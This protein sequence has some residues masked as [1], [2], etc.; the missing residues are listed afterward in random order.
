MLGDTRVFDPDSLHTGEWVMER[1]NQKLKAIIF[2]LYNGASVPAEY[3]ELYQE[4]GE[5]Q[6]PA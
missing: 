4:I 3:V 2:A 1:Q 5:R 6:V